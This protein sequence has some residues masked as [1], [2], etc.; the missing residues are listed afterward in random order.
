[1]NQTG[2]KNG[3]IPG[4]HD[5]ANKQEHCMLYHNITTAATRR[6]LTY[7]DSKEETS[8]CHSESIP[9]AWQRNQNIEIIPQEET[10][11]KRGKID[12][13]LAL[14]DLEI[15]YISSINLKNKRQRHGLN[16]IF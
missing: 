7:S 12:Q 8:Q 11:W 16:K 9:C 6:A 2:D 5:T 14:S 4:D 15:P 1:M 13:K 3:V 10:D